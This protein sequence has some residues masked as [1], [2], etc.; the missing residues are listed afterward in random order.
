[1]YAKGARAS[2]L[3]LG[4]LA[5][6]CGVCQA[7]DLDP[8]E[9]ERLRLQAEA[10]LAGDDEPGQR[11]EEERLRRAAFADA[12][13]DDPL[14]QN[15][16]NAFSSMANR[17][18]AFNP[19]I[20]VF[21]D[22]L[23]R[24]SASQGELREN[25]GTPDE[26]AVD[27]RVSLREVELD[28]RADID[29]YS[30]GVLIVAFED[31]G[32][33]YEVTIEEGY[34]T[35][36][37]L[38]WGFRA[39]A[40]RFRVPF[41]RINQLHTHDLP[42]ATRPFQLLDVFGE[43]GYVD[44]GGILSWLAPWFPLELK[45]AVMQGEGPDILGEGDLDDP[46]YLGRAEY[47]IQFTDTIFLSI[48]ASYLFNFND[49]PGPARQE[50]H[51]SGAD[52]MFKWQPNQFESLVVQG[53]LFQLKREITSRDAEYSFGG[54][55]FVQ[56]QPFQRWYFGVRYDYGDYDEQVENTNQWAVGAWVSFY[57][58]EFL[59]FRVGYEHRERQTTGGGDRD[60][61]TVFFQLTFV[62]GSHP[63]EPFWFNK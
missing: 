15:L 63:V 30:K 11:S 53:E 25:V 59:R 34:I 43:E 50:T 39:K 47:F 4:V 5:A 22:G 29:T 44:N 33:E 18:N 35:L 61:D 32:G 19:R 3:A 1:M 16:L 2:A 12:E 26:F 60:L 9:I 52:F 27:D 38:P 42:Q 7:Q 48:G 46:A 6:L 56:Y 28:F 36:E 17:L 10:E 62:F 58:T 57:T 8:D 14:Y 49:R 45:F 51:V 21:G 54:Y 55:A 40:G 41:G 37:T 31:E 20:T 23:A 24:V 13:E